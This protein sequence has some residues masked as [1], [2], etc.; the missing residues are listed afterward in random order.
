MKIKR[1][2][3]IV[4]LICCFALTSLSAVLMYTVLIAESSPFEYSMLFPLSMIPTGILSI[5]YHVKTLKHYSLSYVYKELNDSFLWIGNLLF[6][7]SISL[8]SLFMLYSVYNIIERDFGSEILYVLIFCIVVLLIGVLLILEERLLYKKYIIFK[9]Q[10]RINKI[11][12]IRGYKDDE[13]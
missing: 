2:F 4:L 5:I 11:E 1:F 6:A 3:K 7:I 9:K 10:S 12:D 13:L 8:L